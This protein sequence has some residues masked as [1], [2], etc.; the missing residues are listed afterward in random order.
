MILQTTIR[1][2][3]TCT[4]PKPIIVI[5]SEERK[6]IF[7]KMVVSLAKSLTDPKDFSAPEID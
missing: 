6:D 3:S 2:K 1:G 7:K 5:D 4:P